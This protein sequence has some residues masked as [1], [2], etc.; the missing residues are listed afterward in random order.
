M[1]R[2]LLHCWVHR[3]EGSSK[4]VLAL[5]ARASFYKQD[6]KWIV[7][8]LTQPSPVLLITQIAQATKMSSLT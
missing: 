5:P 2:W 3:T 6:F 1:N 4:Q 7:Q 8:Q